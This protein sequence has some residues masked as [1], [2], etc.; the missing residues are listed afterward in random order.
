MIRKGA[1]GWLQALSSVLP[2]TEYK[3]QLRPATA[4]L[5]KSGT[6]VSLPG[7]TAGSAIWIVWGGWATSPLEPQF[8]HLYIGVARVT[9]QA[10]RRLGAHVCDGL[11]NLAAP[12]HY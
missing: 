2:G 9:L 7:L 6:R 10:V 4:R 12:S 5:G 11:R 1:R 8:A 3:Y